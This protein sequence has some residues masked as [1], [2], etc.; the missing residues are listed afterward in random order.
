M[1]Y[2]PVIAICISILSLGISWY[3]LYRDKSRLTIRANIFTDQKSKKVLEIRAV[4]VGRRPL[5]I[6][7]FGLRHGKETSRTSIVPYEFIDLKEQLESMEHH[8]AKE[9][10]V[11]LTEGEMFRHCITRDDASTLF[12]AGVEE[13][14]EKVWIEDALGKRFCIPG[15][16]KTLKQFYK[17]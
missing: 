16:K 12:M 11:K 7:W 6:N 4:N 13:F 1:K 17:Q 3:S 15:I 14:A 5:Y 8:K 10:F 2:L 9:P